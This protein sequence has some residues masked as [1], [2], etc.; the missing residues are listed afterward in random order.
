MPIYDN[1]TQFDVILGLEAS[2]T[3]NGTTD[4]AIIDASK[5]ERLTAAMACTVRTDGTYTLKL[6]HGDAANLSDAETI[7]VDSGMLIYNALPAQ[8]AVMT[9][10]DNCP[11][12]GVISVKR[13]VRA[14]IVATGVT[15]GGRVMVVWVGTALAQ[16]TEQD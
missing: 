10:G 8:S 16:P 1:A 12:E 3:G 13:Y 9:D 11:K 2:I 5:Y 4:G 6:E 15:T 14:S 7:A